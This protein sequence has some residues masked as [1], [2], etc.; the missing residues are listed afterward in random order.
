MAFSIFYLAILTEKS[1]SLRISEILLDKWQVTSSAD[2]F[3]MRQP[4]FF[5]NILFLPFQKIKGIIPR[6]I[7]QLR[8]FPRAEYFQL[9]FQDEDV[10]CTVLHS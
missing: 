3:R 4:V 5:Q 10:S 7:D 6:F 2:L 9:M 1:P 8:Q